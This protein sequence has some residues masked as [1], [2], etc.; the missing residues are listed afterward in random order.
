M[1]RKYKI[2][3]V[4]EM[5]GISPSIIRY[6]EEKGLVT[7][8]K[9]PGNG[10]RLFSEEDVF[11]IWDVT[12][13]RSFDMGLDDIRCLFRGTDLDERIAIISEHR[14]RLDELLKEVE[15]NRLFCDFTM[16]YAF[17]AKEVTKPPY[18]SEK[19]IY[20]LYPEEDFYSRT[21]PLFPICTFGCIFAEQGRTHYTIVY[22]E[23]RSY[24]DLGPGQTLVV[25]NVIVVTVCTDIY[26][27]PVAPLQLAMAKAEAAGFRVK[28]PY[29]V[30][31]LLNQGTDSGNREFY[32]RIL[33]TPEA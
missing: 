16:R 25:E 5:I 6:Y 20:Q 30:I 28:L 10:Y 22:E 29:Y 12:F 31:F 1:A 32:Y 17:R 3:E 11:K 8:E 9:D 7:P 26:P 2:R 27:D 33:L 18:L 24:G 13:F 19:E 15:R 4:A 23:D 21:S 14:K